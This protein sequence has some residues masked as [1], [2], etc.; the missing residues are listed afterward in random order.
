MAVSQGCLL[1]MSFPNALVW[2]INWYG[3]PTD[4]SS[5]SGDSC[6]HTHLSFPWSV[7][8]QLLPGTSGHQLNI[9]I[10]DSLGSTW[11]L[12]RKACSGSCNLGH[13]DG[14]E[15][16][17]ATWCY[18]AYS[19]ELLASLCVLYSHAITKCRENCPLRQA[20]AEEAQEGGQKDGMGLWVAHYRQQASSSQKV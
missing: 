6:Q 2:M 3:Q 12:G 8:T 14:E 5:Q 10:K 19:C 20:K 9:K 4:K 1:T 11:W 15:Q 16:T 17:R 7:S 18:K 13:R